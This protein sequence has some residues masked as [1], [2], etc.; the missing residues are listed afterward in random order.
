MDGYRRRTLDDELDELIG[1]LPAVALEGAKGV[2]KTATAHRRASTTI[3]LDNRAQLDLALADPARMLDAPG[4]VLLDEWQRAPALWDAV[5]RAVDDGHPPGPFLL[6]GS[7][8]P[9]DAASD[10]ARHS[11][12][13]RI[14]V[15][16]MRPMTLAERLDVPTT[17][18]LAGL[19]AG[20][21]EQI[22]G[23]TALTLA[24]YATEIV[25]SGFPGLRDLTGRALRARLD[26]YVARVID[27]DIP[28]ELGRPV[29]RPD[30]LRRWLTAYAAATA[31]TT[32]L[33]KIRDAASAGDATPARTTALHYRDAL[34]RLFI[35]DPVDGWLPTQRPLRRTGQAPKHHLVDPALTA[36]LLGLDERMLLAGAPSS[37]N[38]R[39]GA[40]LGPLFES[41]ACL[42]VRVGAQRAEARV[43]HLRTRA[44]EHEID[45]IVESRDG[46]VLALE[47]KLAQTVSDDD[48]KHLLWLREQLGNGLSDAVVLTTGPHAY[49]RADGIAVVPLGLL[50]P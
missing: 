31:T 36:A 43:R 25:R 4:P 24:D 14:D 44:G 39:D 41:L 13:G 42:S 9:M 21:R 5:R 8:A 33:E 10:P 32:S 46:R 6:T 40:A 19:L 34:T 2:G 12:A 29:R 49:R 45:L 27:R 1:A 15:L 16:R 37:G 50:G 28:D 22:G 47:V 30:T 11:G 18:S 7:A 38:P 17:V 48:V 23:T 3:L 35:L 20:G 26:G